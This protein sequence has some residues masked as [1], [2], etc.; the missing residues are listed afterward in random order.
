MRHTQHTVLRTLTLGLL[1]L[2]LLAWAGGCGFPTQTTISTGNDG[3]LRTLVIPDDAEVFI[4]GGSMGP[5][6]Q[7]RG[8]TFIRMKAGKHVVEIKK[9]GYQTYRDEVFVSNN[10][11]TITVML[12]KAE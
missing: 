8:R 7:F 3:G 1:A 4:D 2:G 10:M 6:S 9:P 5:A 11:I 12:K